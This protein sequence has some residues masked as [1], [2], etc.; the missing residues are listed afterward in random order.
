M[1]L[2]KSRQMCHA[3]QVVLG[4]VGSSRIS[5]RWQKNVPYQ[6]PQKINSFWD[7]FVLGI[8]Y[9]I[10]ERSSNLQACSALLR[11][12]AKSW[13]SFEADKS[14]MKWKM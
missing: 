11:V 5:I 2:E 6:I 4:R 9:M 12:D 8:L 1:S 14:W 3:R 7:I 13:F 10:V